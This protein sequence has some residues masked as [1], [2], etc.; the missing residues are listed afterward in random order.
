MANF[1]DFDLDIVT[2]SKKNSNFEPRI[3]SLLFCTPGCATGVVL[4][5]K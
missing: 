5:P 1:D 3:E 4:C 2:A